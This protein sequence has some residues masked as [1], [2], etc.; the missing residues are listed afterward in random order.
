[1]I[2]QEHSEEGFRRFD[3]FFFEE[4]NTHYTQRLTTMLAHN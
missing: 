1:M 2:Y 4:L 3:Q